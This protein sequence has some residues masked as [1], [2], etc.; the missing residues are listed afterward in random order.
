MK[1]VRASQ[2]NPSDK[3][4][5]MYMS[6]KEA[7]LFKSLC[8]TVTCDTLPPT[9]GTIP[10]ITRQWILEL[11]NRDI[12]ANNAYVLGQVKVPSNGE[13]K[14]AEDFIDHD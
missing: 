6:L 14:L 1:C 7:M 4:V 8:R 13:Q 2:F 5:V 11:G 10:A 3:G 12:M 9:E